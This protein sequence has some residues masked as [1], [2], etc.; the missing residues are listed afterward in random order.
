GVVMRDLLR[1]AAVVAGA[2]VVLMGSAVGAAPASAAS[3]LT[4]SRGG[5]PVASH[6]SGIG[7]GAGGR[8][9]PP[10]SPGSYSGRPVVPAATGSAAGTVT[11]YQ[12]VINEP[13]GVAAGPD[14]ALWFANY[15]NNSIGRI[16]TTGQ[17]TNYTAPFVGL[18]VGITAGPDGA[19]WFTDI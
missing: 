14:G 8:A 12:D 6:Q 10:S 18:P 7:N 16:S 15:S 9:G 13:D 3:A 4:W 17:I 2:S 11:N 5:M 19:L 1:G